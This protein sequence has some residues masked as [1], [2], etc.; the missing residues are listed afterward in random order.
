MIATGVPGLIVCV[1]GVRGSG[2]CQRCSSWGLALLWPLSQTVHSPSLGIFEGGASNRDIFTSG[3]P[4][5]QQNWSL[6]I[7]QLFCDLG[8]SLYPV[9]S[10]TECRE[11]P[12]LLRDMKGGYEK[13]SVSIRAGGAPQ[14]AQLSLFSRGDWLLPCR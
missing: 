9:F 5:T 6:A 2:S 11:S 7:N 13:R 8:K 1:D 14:P 12:L 10:H 4:Q 3:L